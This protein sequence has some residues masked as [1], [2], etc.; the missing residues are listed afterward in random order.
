M[1]TERK[2]YQVKFD[3]DVVKR[4]QEKLQFTASIL[5]RARVMDS[6]TYRRALK[7]GELRNDCLQALA[8]FIGC[9]RSE[10]LPWQPNQGNVK[11]QPFGLPSTEEWLID[12]E[13]LASEWM[14]TANGL[15][16]RICRMKHRTI[17]NHFGRGKFYDLLSVRKELRE[18]L[19]HRLERHAVVGMTISPCEW[20][21]Q[22][23]SCVPAGNGEGWWVIDRWVGS[24]TLSELIGQQTEAKSTC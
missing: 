5:E 2:L 4:W 1:A 6:E 8:D 17:E 12:G 19:K 21:P 24:T 18:K 9:E 7:S 13:V 15:D 14:K 22:F 3:T 23:Y 16:Y 20:L 11:Q 10:L